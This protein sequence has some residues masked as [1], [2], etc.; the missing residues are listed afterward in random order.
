M[1]TDAGEVSLSD[2]A[3]SERSICCAMTAVGPQLGTLRPLNP[4]GG[5]EHV[6][7]ARGSN[8]LKA[9]PVHVVT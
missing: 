8:N 6:G 9:V 1:V 2:V 5:N 4:K 3:H 7:R